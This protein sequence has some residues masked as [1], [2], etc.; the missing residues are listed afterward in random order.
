MAI[1]LFLAVSAAT[2]N[3]LA[4]SNLARVAGEAGLTN[5]EATWLVI[6]FVSGSAFANLVVI[7]GRQQFGVG[8]M[9]RVLIGLDLVSGLVCIV[10]PAY[11]ALIFNRGCN[12][13][14]VSTCVA[15]GIYYFIQALPKSHRL[16]AIVIGISTVQMST[17]LAAFMPVEM[18]TALGNAGFVRIATAIS[19]IALLMV[20]LF[21]LPPTST[22]RVINQFDGLSAGLIYATMLPLTAVLA[23]GR[24]LWWTDTPWLGWLLVMA[25]ICA[26]A[27]IAMELCRTRPLLQMEWLS[28]W[29]VIQFVSI[30]VLERV[31]LGEQTTGAVGLLSLGGLINDQLHGFYAWIL[32]GMT[33][34]TISVA[35]L[36]TPK[37]IPVLCIVAL[38][39]IAIAAWIDTGA[40][41]LSRPR[42]LAFSQTLLGFG[43][44]LFV[45]PALLYGIVLVLKSDLSHFVPTVLVF[46]AAQSLGSVIGSAL[47]G[48]L[49]YYYQQYNLTNLSAQIPATADMAARIRALGA[50][51]LSSMLQTQSSVL[52]Y[53]NVF[54]FVRD[55]AIA[56][57]LFMVARI[58]WTSWRATHQEKAAQ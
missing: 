36:L 34:G 9:Q 38:V 4:S 35:I 23:L 42:E 2:E 44:T 3:A 16:S 22:G 45:G 15:S 37:T 32:L 54:G 13:L 11:P 27:A 20:M 29:V 39:L 55:L 21:P 8:F 6:A 46:S 14:M 10:W 5:A 24:T 49:Q 58:A 18:L 7:K 52:G 1:G 26:A 43:T 53:L 19:A 33:A 48:S 41:A 47:L 12:G 28:S 30:A 40:N 51:N 57:A 50:S 56:V 25:V 31:M 17:P